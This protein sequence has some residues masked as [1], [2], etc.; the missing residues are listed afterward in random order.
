MTTRRT[1]ITLVAAALLTAS[2]STLAIDEP[3]EPLYEILGGTAV[4]S[5]W[6]EILWDSYPGEDDQSARTEDQQGPIRGTFFNG[7][8]AA[9]GIY[10]SDPTGGLRSI[11][12]SSARVSHEASGFAMEW[13]IVASTNRTEAFPNSRTRASGSTRSRAIFAVHRPTR[14]RLSLTWEEAMDQDFSSYSWECLSESQRSIFRIG[15]LDSQDYLQYVD[16]INA[17]DLDRDGAEELGMDHLFHDWS[18]EPDT[19]HMGNPSNRSI[20]LDLEPGIYALNNWG[21]FQILHPDEG[22]YVEMHLHARID[23]HFEESMYSTDL[24][25]DGRVDGGDLNTLLGMWG[26]SDT[27]ADFNHDG[28]VDGA[29]LN[30]LLGD[31]S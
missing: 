17:F 21:Q 30:I 15:D 22:S 20:W 25:Q 10:L 12:D 13:N 14:I 29:D 19:W 3:C 26:T 2:S 23:V 9:D 1:N 4:A 5:G 7:A 31:W 18:Y 6:G 27:C 8:M 24:N 11:V 28:V 16:E